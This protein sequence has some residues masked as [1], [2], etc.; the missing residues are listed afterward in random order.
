[1]K[2]L[3]SIIGLTMMMAWTLD[4]QPRLELSQSEIDLGTVYGGMPVMGR[5]EYKNSG[6]D[7]LR[8]NF[9]PTC[10]CTTIKPPKP[11]LLPK[12][13]DFV[14]F[15]FNSTGYHGKV[16]KWISIDSNDPRTPNVGVRFIANVVSDLEPAGNAQSAWVT[17]NLAVGQTISDTRNFVNSSGHPLAIKGVTTSAPSSLQAIVEKKTLKP[18]ESIPI[19]ITVKGERIGFM[20][21]HIFVQTDSKKQPQVDIPISYFVTQDSKK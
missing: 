9:H 8:V 4:A 14:E 17:A 10:G 13:S 15:E 21:E 19:S 11:F 2:H 18:S 7:T 16:E 6:K 20:R 3:L 1:M 12:E 5:I